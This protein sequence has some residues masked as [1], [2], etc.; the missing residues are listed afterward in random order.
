MLQ[1]NWLEINDEP[2]HT[3]NV[4]GQIKFNT[5]MLRLSFEDYSDAY[6]QVKRTMA[7]TIAGDCANAQGQAGLNIVFFFL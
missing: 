5:V 4:G 1:K 3:C 7:T 6:I 2:R